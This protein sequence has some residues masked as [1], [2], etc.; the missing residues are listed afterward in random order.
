[1]PRIYQEMLATTTQLNDVGMELPDIEGVH[2]VTDVTGFGVLGHALEMC[3]GASLA[4]TSREPPALLPGRAAPCRS[5]LRHRR[6]EAQLAELWRG[7]RPARGLPDWRRHLLCDP[8]TSGGLLIACAPQ[9]ETEVLEL[10]RRRGFDHACTIGSFAAGPPRIAV[11][12]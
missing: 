8:Q 6:V 5:G 4:S 10:V 3:R 12:A 1:M 11:S 2:A 7:D 9:A